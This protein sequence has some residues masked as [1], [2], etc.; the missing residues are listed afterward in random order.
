MYEYQ[1]KILRI[2]D[3]DTLD[4]EISLGFEIYKRERLRLNRINTPEVH[5]ADSVRGKQ[6]SRRVEALAPV[7]SMVSIRTIK[8]SQEKYGRYLAEVFIEQPGFHAFNLN[9]TL[10][11]EGLAVLYDGGKR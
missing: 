9:D 11:S 3:G 2:V 7:G 10:V 8:D 5:G 4:V 1:A 6:A